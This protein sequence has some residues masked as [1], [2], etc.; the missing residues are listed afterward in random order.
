MTCRAMRV[1]LLPWVWGRLEVWGGLE[2]PPWFAMQNFNPIV[3]NAL[4]AD[5][6][7]ATSVR[8]PCALLVP[9]LRLIHP[10]RRRFMTVHLP[11]QR[12]EPFSH[13]FFKCLQSLPN[14][15]TLEVALAEGAENTAT[16]PL[17]KALR[18]VKL[19]Q[20]KTLI[21]PPAAHPLLQ[22]CCGVEDIVC[23]NMYKTRSPDGFLRSLA[24]NRDSKIKRLAI[25]LTLW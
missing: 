7:L 14:L 21:I 3:L 19:P 8:Y 1:R 16:T 10:L 18:R 20:V 24:P 25:P 11:Y 12:N 13:L 22:H 5:T 23:M 4:R 15:H 6:F 17:K 9:G 2:V